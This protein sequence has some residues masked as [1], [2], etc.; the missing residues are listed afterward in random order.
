ME[1][2]DN[3]KYTLHSVTALATVLFIYLN[4][5]DIP[6]CL[7]GVHLSSAVFFAIELVCFVWKQNSAARQKKSLWTLSAVLLSFGQLILCFFV[8]HF[9]IIIF[10]AP[11]LEQ[12]EETSSLSLLL[13]VLCLARTLLNLGPSAVVQCL[14]AN[15]VTSVG[16]SEAETRALCCLLGAWIGA[17]PIPLDWDRPWQTWPLTCVVG[18][19]LGEVACNLRQLTRSYATLHES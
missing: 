5:I 17:L 7:S 19:L 1:W 6:V 10:G 3:L 11:I 15:K 13:S 16:Q 12:V 18:S 14:S 2:C 8:L 4:A 9:G